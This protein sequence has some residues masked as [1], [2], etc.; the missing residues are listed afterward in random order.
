MEDEAVLSLLDKISSSETLRK[1]FFEAIQQPAESHNQQNVE[2]GDTESGNARDRETDP[3]S[4]NNNEWLGSQVVANEYQPE[5]SSLGT[6]VARQ[7][8]GVSG[9]VADEHQLMANPLV[10][11]DHQGAASEDLF[12]EKLQMFDPSSLSTSDDFTFETHEVITQYLET[13]FRSSLNKDVPNGMHKA[14]P[15]LCTLIMKVPKVDRYILDYLRQDFPKSCDS[16]LSIIQSTLIL[17]TGPLT[18]LWAE[19]LKTQTL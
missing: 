10:T 19:L 11:R 5:H 2:Q 4:D 6:D 12:Q 1:N 15:V 17:A 9:L 3:L 8:R 16:D 7:S 18:C 13:H 14:H